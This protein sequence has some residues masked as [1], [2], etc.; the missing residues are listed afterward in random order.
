MLAI[1]ETFLSEA[2]ADI[3]DHLILQQLKYF[4]PTDAD[5]DFNVIVLTDAASCFM[6]GMQFVP[7]IFSSSV[8]L[9]CICP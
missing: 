4:I 7:F 9:A 1:I 8:R 5:G 6:L 3:L 2:L